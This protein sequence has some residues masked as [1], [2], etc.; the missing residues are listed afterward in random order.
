[1]SIQICNAGDV[2]GSSL[3]GV[4]LCSA[5]PAQ[6]YVTDLHRGGGIITSVESKR[7]YCFRPKGGGEAGLWSRGED[8]GLQLSSEQRVLPVKDVHRAFAVTG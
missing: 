2:Y 6:L 7:S 8:E 1:M 4:L 5:R 3:V